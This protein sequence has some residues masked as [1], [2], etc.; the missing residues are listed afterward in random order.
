MAV[1]NGVFPVLPGKEDDARKFGEEAL[2]SHRDHYDALMK[3]SGTSRVTWTI[4]ETP[5]GTFLAVWFEADDIEA[6]FEILATGTGADADWMRG[7]VKEVTG[8]DVTEPAAS[9][10]PEVILE[11]P[12]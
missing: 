2:G 1:F 9:P 7:R 8:V 4:Q 5:A 12:A 3:A 10:L 6:I 11:W